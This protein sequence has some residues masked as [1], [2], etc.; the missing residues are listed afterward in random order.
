ML[1]VPYW[2]SEGLKCIR[3]EVI[4][5]QVS[6]GEFSTRVTNH[7]LF[8]V[9]KEPFNYNVILGH[10][11]LNL[12]RVVSSPLHNRVKFPTP[13]GV[14]Q[15]VGNI[16]EA[17]ECYILSTLGATTSILTINHQS[18]PESPYGPKHA[19][20]HKGEASQRKQNRN[21]RNIERSFPC[22]RR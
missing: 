5:L 4:H 19:R 12:F 6:M 1:Q 7:V 13:N 11:G 16:R 2:G 17:C 3:E 22:G 20:E 21:S 14:G 10:L 18:H 8:V 15:E 9:V